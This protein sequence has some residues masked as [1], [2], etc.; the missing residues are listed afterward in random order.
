MN[1]DQLKRLAEL[2]GAEFFPEWVGHGGFNGPCLLWGKPWR[3]P[4]TNADLHMR[5]CVDY[6]IEWEKLG[7]SAYQG[8]AT[9]V[10]GDYWNHIYAPSAEDDIFACTTIY[11]AIRAVLLAKLEAATDEQA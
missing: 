5:W 11:E 4:F 8:C 10:N 7:P 9:A 1:N 3:E 2:L 6:E